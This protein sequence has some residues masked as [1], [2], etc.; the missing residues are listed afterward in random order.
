MSNT[1][2]NTVDKATMLEGILKRLVAAMSWDN[3]NG[4]AEIYLDHLKVL[5]EAYAAAGLQP[6]EMPVKGFGEND[7]ING[8]PREADIHVDEYIEQVDQQLAEDHARIRKVMSTPVTKG[9]DV[10]SVPLVDVFVNVEATVPQSRLKCEDLNIKGTYRVQVPRDLETSDQAGIALDLFDEKVGISEPAHFDVQVIKVM[11]TSP[12][13][14]PGS[15]S[16]LG[17]FKG[18]HCFHPSLTPVA[19]KP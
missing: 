6:L 2:A 4:G 19:R 18:A 11:K 5:N 8:I 3:G 7:V 13:Y 15:L 16:H 10:T 9:V 1:T 12:A 17:A 14:Q